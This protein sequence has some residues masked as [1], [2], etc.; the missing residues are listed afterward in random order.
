[1]KYLYWIATGLIALMMVASGVMYFISEDMMQNIARLGYPD[2]FRVTLGIAKLIGAAALLLPLPR[3]VKEWA[4]AG[5]AITFV[6]AFIAH[7]AAGDPMGDIIPP[8]VALVILLTSYYGYHAYY[9]ADA[10]SEA[11]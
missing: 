10:A 9:R 5:F 2:H 8:V 1:M 6:S 4:Y 3:S 11:A 7:V